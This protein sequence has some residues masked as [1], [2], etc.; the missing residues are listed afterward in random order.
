MTTKVII[1]GGWTDIINAENSKFYTEI[2]KDTKENLKILL[3]LFAKPESEWAV[4]VA[5]HNR[6]I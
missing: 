4:K 1:S 2:L 6:P 3:I 5:M